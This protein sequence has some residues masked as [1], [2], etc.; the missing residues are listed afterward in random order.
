M[1]EDPAEVGQA[2]HELLVVH[3]FDTGSHYTFPSGLELTIQLASNSLLTSCLSL[4]KAGIIDM[5]HHAHLRVVTFLGPRVGHGHDEN[6]RNTTHS[7][8]DMDFDSLGIYQE[9][10]LIAR[11]QTRNTICEIKGWNGQ[12]TKKG[13]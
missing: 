7:F 3:A 10:A 1:V 2:A 4:L 5:H 6:T 11:A 9:Q 8:K 12:K 13:S